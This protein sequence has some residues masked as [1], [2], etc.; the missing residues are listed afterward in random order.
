MQNSSIKFIINPASGNKKG[1]KIYSYLKQ[2]KPQHKII[3]SEKKQG[4]FKSKIKKFVNKN[5]LIIIC[6]GD[7]TVNSVINCLYKINM[8]DEIKL[9]VY[10]IGTGNDLASSLNSNKIKDINIFIQKINTHKFNL[11]KIPSFEIE[12]NNNKNLFINYFSI[13]LDS[14]AL[15]QCNSYRS[16]KSNKK[17]PTFILKIAYALFGIRNFFHKITQNTY[18]TFSDKNINISNHSCIIAVNITSYAGG[19]KLV[20]KEDLTKPN[21]AI[22]ICKSP[23][24]YYKLILTRF[25]S[26]KISYKFIKNLSKLYAQNLEIYNTTPNLRLSKFQYDGEIK[27][28]ANIKQIN[29]K[30]Y[31]NISLVCF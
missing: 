15:D 14:E 12:F 16:K 2:N 27:D 5:D 11:L 19:S 28:I 13:G 20:L 17:L 22:F 31:K 9:A 4:E 24:S 8:I 7:G 25:L 30:L 21:L 3:L 18:L 23:L 10:P 1:L 29:I 26:E 6:G